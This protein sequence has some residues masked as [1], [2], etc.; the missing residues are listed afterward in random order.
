MNDR[1]KIADRW[2]RTTP[3]RRLTCPTCHAQG[4]TVGAWMDAHARHVECPYC[5]RYITAKGW[6]MHAHAMHGHV[7]RSRPDPAPIDTPDGYLPAGARIRH[8]NRP[9]R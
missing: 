7:D 3:A 8:P 6:R 2:Y 9:A 1:S 4:S 5:G